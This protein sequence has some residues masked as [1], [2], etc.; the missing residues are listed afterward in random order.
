VKTSPTEFAKFY[1]LLMQGAP[2]GYTPHFFVVDKSDKT[3]HT[4]R[5][6]WSTDKNTKTAEQSI[7]L[8]RRGFNLGIAAMDDNLIIVDIDDEDAID[9]ATIVPTLSVRSRS[10]TGTHNFYYIDIIDDKRNIAVPNVGELRAQHQYVVCA[11]SYATTDPCNVP[12][13][14]R[15]LAGFYTVENNVPPTHITFNQLPLIFRRQYI[16]NY[17]IPSVK[18][19]FADMARIFDDEPMHTGE[20]RSKSGLFDLEVSDIVSVPRDGRNFESPL[21]GSKNGKNSTYSNGWMHCFRCGVSHNATTLLAV[22][23]GI[24]TCGSAGFGHKY[25]ASGRSSIDMSD[26]ETVYM[27]WDYAR[28]NNYLP[29][30]DPPPNAALRYFVVETGICKEEDIEDGWRVPTYAY[31]EAIHLLSTN[32]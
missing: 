18:D 10:R 20:K 32:I 29:A 16:F 4:A 17:L 11:G 15:E 12:D 31:R 30:N 8:M 6:A 1:N 23:A 25:S 3:P 2:E 5:G 9:P 21:H 19:R 27:I 24:S 26:D 7:N 22:M 13:S 28:R 14:E